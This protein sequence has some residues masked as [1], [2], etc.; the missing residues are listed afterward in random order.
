MTTLIMNDRSINEVLQDFGLSIEEI[1]VYLAV[2]ELGSQPASVIAK[3]ANLKRGQTYNK[4]ANL[5]QKGIIQEYFRDKVRY[6][7]CRS[8]QSLNAVLDRREEDLKMS[9]QKLQRILPFLEKIR[10]PFLSQP[11]VRF[12]QGVEGIKEI[13][14]D[15]LRVKDSDIFAVSDF[16]YI[17]PEDMDKELHDWI[18]NYAK[19]RANRGVWYFGIVNGS[20]FSNKAYETRVKEKRKLKMLKDIYLPVEFNIYG[21]KVAVTSTYKDMVGIIIE[22]AHIAETLRNFHQAVWKFLP[23]YKL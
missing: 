10:N 2:L 22:D 13:Y 5:I 1:S 8:P 3:K 17:F 7:T 21:D 9:K 4:L 15:T 20:K 18:W 19:R 12:F 14:E 16:D 23:D 6:F 11:K